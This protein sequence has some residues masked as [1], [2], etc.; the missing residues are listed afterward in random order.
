MLVVLLQMYQAN[1]VLNKGYSALYWCAYMTQ[2]AKLRELFN[3]SD[4]Q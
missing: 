2:S 1:L 3:P 4:F